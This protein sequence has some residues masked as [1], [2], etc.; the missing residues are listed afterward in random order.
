M[1]DEFLKKR[2][3]T[4]QLSVCHDSTVESC[5]VLSLR[6]MS[7]FV[8]NYRLSSSQLGEP[9]PNLLAGRLGP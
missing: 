9:V 1:H 8:Q 4:E 3:S 2:C 6:T 5:R 7:H